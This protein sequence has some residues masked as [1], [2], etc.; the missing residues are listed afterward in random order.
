MWLCETDPSFICTLHNLHHFMVTFIITADLVRRPLNIKT[1]GTVPLHTHTHTHTPTQREGGWVSVCV[2]Y[3]DQCIQE[4]ITPS[5]QRSRGAQWF[6]VPLSSVINAALLLNEP[7][8]CCMF[9]A[10]FFFGSVATTAWLLPPLRGH[11]HWHEG[12]PSALCTQAV[13][14][15]NQ[16]SVIREHIQHL[17]CHPS[18]RDDIYGIFFC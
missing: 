18:S 11:S 3:G 5:T 15:I 4:G 7:L 6:T 1:V 14:A 2:Y 17:L 12:A 10:C 13:Q 16:G 9:P 8:T